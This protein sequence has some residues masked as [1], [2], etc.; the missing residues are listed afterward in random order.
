MKENSKWASV[1]LMATPTESKPDRFMSPASHTWLLSRG[2]LA[3]D[4]ASELRLC[5][6]VTLGL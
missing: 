4:C 2:R 3:N 5:S 1:E 6:S